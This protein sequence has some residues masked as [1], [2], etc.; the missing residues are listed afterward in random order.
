MGDLYTS[1]ADPIFYLHHANLDRLWWSWQ[2]LNLS[3]RLTDISGPINLM[4]YGNA[5][6]GNVT[7]D[8]PLSVGVSAANVTVGDVMNIKGC[9]TAGV[10]CYEY[11]KLYTL[12]H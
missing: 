1:P 4:D 5:Q 12:Q 2:K 9:G 6:G 11:D 3:T 10:L 7:L 8:F